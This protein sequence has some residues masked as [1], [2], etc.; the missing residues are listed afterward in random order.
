[1]KHGLALLAA[2]LLACA[3]PSYA[4]QSTIDFNSLPVP[5]S[6]STYAT[7]SGTVNGDWLIINRNG[8]TYKVLA[9]FGGTCASGM[10]VSAITPQG[11]PVC[12]TVSG[13]GGSGTV[14]N[15]SIGTA[16]GASGT[17]LNSTT[18]AVINLVPTAGGTFASSANNLGFF[19][20]TTS[21]QLAGVVS[22][23][24]GTGSLVFANSATLTTP[25]I[26]TATATSINKVIITAPATSATLTI[27]NGKTLTD[28]NTLTFTGTDS[29]SIAF[30]TGGTVVYTGVAT[31]SSLSS[32][33]TI[34]TGVW[35]GT[36]IASAYIG[37]TGVTAGTYTSANITVN[38]EG[39]VTS[40]ANGTG[41]G[42]GSAFIG[43]SALLSSP[44]VASD[45]TTGLFN[46]VAHTVSIAA[47]GIGIGTFGPTGLSLATPLAVAS[48]GT[49]LAAPSIVYPET[50]GATGNAATYFD[51]AFT[52]SNSTVAATGGTSTTPATP[53]VTTLAANDWLVSIFNVPGAWT[54][55]PS[56]GT[57][58][59]NLTYSSPDFGL[60]ISDQ[61]IASPST[62]TPVTGLFAAS[63]TWATAS[64]SLVPSGSPSFIA[65]TTYQNNGTSAVTLTKPTGTT[66]GDFLL[67][68]MTYNNLSASSQF[69]NAPQ[70][71]YLVAANQTSTVSTVCYAKTATASEPSSYVFS[72]LALYGSG[73]VTGAMLDY[74]NISGV[75]GA[76][77][78]LT[79]STATFPATASGDDICV[80]AISGSA[81]HIQQTCGTIT[82]YNSSTSVNVSFPVF[83]SYTGLE[84]A[85]GTDD[86]SAFTT[87]MTSAPCSTLGCE[88]QM[89]AKHYALTGQLSVPVNHSIN[90]QGVAAT[91]PNTANS[92]L[93]GPLANAAGGTQLQWFTKGLGVP[94]LVLKGTSNHTNDVGSN[95]IRDLVLVGGVG[96]GLDGA[97]GDGLDILNWQSA[98][99]NNVFIFNFSG[100]GVYVDGV[101]AASYQDYVEDV[102]LDKTFISYNALGGMKVGSSTNIYNIET[103]GFDDGIIEANGGPGLTLA[104]ANI[105]GFSMTN[106][107]VQWDNLFNSNVEV[108][109]SG[110]V[111]GGAFDRDYFEADS[112][113]SS[114]STAVSGNTVGMIGIKFGSNFYT[115][116]YNYTPVTFSAAGTALPACSTSTNVNNLTANVTDATQCN[117]GATYAS[118]G[119][120]KCSVTCTAGVWTEGAGNNVTLG[121][122]KTVNNPARSGDLT[123]GIYSP[124]TSQ[125]AI[126]SA[127]V[128]LVDV[129]T[130]GMSIGSAYIGSAAPT[131]GLIVQ[132][133]V[134]IG[135]T[136]PNAAAIFDLSNNSSAMI[137]PIGSDLQRPTGVNGMVRYNNTIGADESYQ[138]GVWVQLNPQL[139]SGA[140]KETADNGVPIGTQLTTLYNLGA[141]TLVSDIGIPELQLTQSSYPLTT[142]ITMRPWTK[143][144]SIG[145]TALSF[146]GIG[147]S[148]TIGVSVNDDAAPVGR[149]NASANSGNLGS[150]LQG[151]M[152]IVGP[153]SSVGSTTGLE[154]GD[155]TATSSDDNSQRMAYRSD[156]SINKWVN[157]IH[158]RTNN[159]YMNGMQHEQVSFFTKGIVT[160]SNSTN[161]N[162]GER[163]WCWDVTFGNGVH[164]AYNPDS[165]NLDWKC[166]NASFDFVGSVENATANDT[167]SKNSFIG[168]HYEEL[169]DG[170]I[171]TYAGTNPAYVSNKIERHWDDKFVGGSAIPAPA[172]LWQG[173][174]RYLDL[175]GFDVSGYNGGT[176]SAASM[177]MVAPT[178][179]MTGN[180]G[181]GITFT[182]FA[183]MTQANIVTTDD[184]YFANA[185]ANT[186]A[187][188]A[189]STLSED[190]VN[191]IACTI[192]TGTV[193][194]AGGA[195]KSLK[196]TYTGTGNF[197]VITLD[198]FPV[199]AG[200]RLIANVA[201]YG[202]T[203]TG[204]DAVQLQFI[205]SNNNAII[206]PTNDGSVLGD[207]T[208]TLYGGGSRASWGML[209][210]LRQSVVPAGAN[211]AQLSI[212]I[213]QLS[214]GD[215]FR[216]GAAVVN[217][218]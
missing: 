123:T 118:G 166:W 193:W 199:E 4:Q 104:G 198:R 91:V 24:T 14:T 208:S 86:T 70:G 1:M 6:G 173:G 115:P 192:D 67:G 138:S 158:W 164:S 100:Y 113:L 151:P 28:N 92:Y 47:N 124:G 3:C 18:A 19:G 129:G 30:G 217:K 49:G 85:Y 12:T 167:Y 175:S 90:F 83:Q 127:G 102:F 128:A 185:G 46:N 8:V 188:S 218:N 209:S 133:S 55:T 58:R 107:V 215:V 181:K 179:I 134:G 111:Y 44:Q 2:I 65:E 190:S 74:R 16:N 159:F 120:T 69:F 101:T 154:I 112:N 203:S 60:F 131:N 76:V 52:N 20:T 23:E 26:G 205:F 206:S 62:T 63:H 37:T 48:G 212:T 214:S 36:P 96:K 183:Q 177:F 40:A 171:S 13:G 168:N 141:T 140:L 17:V 22:D 33:G 196:F 34:A 152:N 61:V 143:I 200:D 81:A 169:G 174:P 182:N 162:S 189:S 176:L 170:Y 75:D 45:A 194:T 216:V 135:T 156:L 79:S 103:V 59:V 145:S 207:N 201:F 39:Q 121:A 144:K 119:S 89:Q 109:V 57:T 98:N 27:A 7:N 126:A 149:F 64:I 150:Y 163:L 43:T 137:L 202:G 35:N 87:M 142:G 11:A 110:V 25:S 71:F 187:C 73:T 94:A 116:A 5:S 195:T 42:G 29:S 184:P 99:L 51:G 114:L 117:Y 125:T 213:S 31:L 178:I 106:S 172:V 210:T 82:G 9:G 204:T 78:T 130:T 15:V 155:V 180:K 122:S 146:V 108:L 132:G 10:W 38:A 77:N 41:G 197:D 66:T 95:Y 157:A 93:N 153:S 97:G 105:Q 32:I 88:I 191:G 165:P 211:F 84:F 160:D 139:G 147:T 136:A 21:A 50:Y 53:A 186:A 68:C 148:G 54:T 80:A 161:V 56:V 72:L